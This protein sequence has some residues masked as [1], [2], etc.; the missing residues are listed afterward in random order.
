MAADA[1]S[2]TAGRLGL[3]LVLTCDELVYSVALSSER[4]AIAAHRFNR[5]VIR[6]SRRKV[7]HRHAVDHV[8]ETLIPPVG[9]FCPAVEVLG[10]RAVVH[11]RVLD[12][13]TAS[14]CGPSDNGGF[15]R[16]RFREW[17][18][19][20]PHSCERARQQDEFE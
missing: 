11:H 1:V 15:I 12:Q 7:H 10:V 5:V 18:S 20:N 2:G 19:H 17:M 8:R 13:A 14:V 16:R 9:R 3:L 4:R 6:R